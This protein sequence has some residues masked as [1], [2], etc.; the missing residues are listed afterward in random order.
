MALLE[1]A[2]EIGIAQPDQAVLRLQLDL[3]G[4]ALAEAQRMTPDRNVRRSRSPGQAGLALVL[5]PQVLSGPAEE[6][7]DVWPPSLNFP[8]CRRPRALPRMPRDVVAW[9]PD[10]STKKCCDSSMGRK[11]ARLSTRRR[12]GP[13]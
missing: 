7:V 1:I 6:V 3:G 12:T 13:S 4:Q 5:A 11:A 2:T 10:A 9:D 8:A